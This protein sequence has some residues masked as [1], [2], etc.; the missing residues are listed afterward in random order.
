[1]NCVQN[2][3][4]MADPCLQELFYVRKTNYNHIPIIIN[5]KEIEDFKM[6]PAETILFIVKRLSGIYSKD[7]KFLLESKTKQQSALQKI[8]TIMESA[9]NKWTALQKH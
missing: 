5:E 9:T 3:N 2:V 4:P 6:S 7:E 8:T 1:M